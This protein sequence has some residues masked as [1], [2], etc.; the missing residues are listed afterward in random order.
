MIVQAYLRT[1]DMPVKQRVLVVT[2]EAIIQEGIRAVSTDAIAQ[3]LHISKRTIYKLFSTKKVLIKESVNHAL[4]ALCAER[5]AI[6]HSKDSCF[7]KLIALSHL[8]IRELHRGQSP[9]WNEIDGDTT[10][11]EVFS[12]IRCYWKHVFMEMLEECYKQGC[13]DRKYISGREELKMFS[14]IFL[15]VLYGMHITHTPDSLDILRQTA[16]IL[17]RGISSPEY[18]EWMDEYL[19]HSI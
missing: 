6:R 13:F 17:L 5:D 1:E 8:H 18:T 15:Q 10:Y 7:E 11:R 3:T 9:F 19:G 4:G 2:Y 12:G 14:K 16:F